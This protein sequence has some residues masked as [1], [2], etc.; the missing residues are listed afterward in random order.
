VVPA[1]PTP[2]FAALKEWRR[3]RSRA[4][5]V[6]AYMI[7][8]NATLEQIAGRRPQSLAEL[9]AVPGVGPTKLERYGEEVLA[10]LVESG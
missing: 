10:A 6:P 8:H 5:D 3:Q 2:E 4:D 9:A 7:F 1:T